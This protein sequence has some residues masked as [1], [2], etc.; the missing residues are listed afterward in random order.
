MGNANS[1][2]R[3]HEENENQ[4]EENEETQD[5]HQQQDIG[6]IE[7][8]PP[9]IPP[10]TPPEVDEDLGGSGGEKKDEES[11]VCP[12]RPSIQTWPWA[13]ALGLSFGA[14]ISLTV[15]VILE[16]TTTQ[17]DEIV[18]KVCEFWQEERRFGLF[19]RIGSQKHKIPESH[20]SIPEQNRR[21]F[22]LHPVRKIFDPTFSRH[23][24]WI[25][26]FYDVEEKKWV[27]LVQKE[28][29]EKGEPPETERLIRN[30]KD[31]SMFVIKPYFGSET[32][33]SIFHVQANREKKSKN[34]S[35]L[36][37]QQSPTLAFR[38]CTTLGGRGVRGEGEKK[39]NRRRTNVKENTKLKIEVE[40]SENTFVSQNQKAI[41]KEFMPKVHN[42]FSSDGC[43]SFRVF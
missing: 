29:G 18:G 22:L 13:V 4:Y 43:V 37:S 32:V 2:V 6:D 5:I 14:I 40:P 33:C 25:F 27:K 9:Y 16:L 42:L 38:R 1:T 39:G 34:S 30:A 12:S 21:K 15:L 17:N 10:P 11:L 24:L 23:P 28:D 26:R 20:S 41:L 31:A 7:L 19:S 35:T 3:V 36:R 8:T